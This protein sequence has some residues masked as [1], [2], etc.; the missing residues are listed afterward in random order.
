MR[1]S[2]KMCMRIFLFISDEVGKVLIDGKGY[3]SYAA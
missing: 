2:G 1:V 3:F